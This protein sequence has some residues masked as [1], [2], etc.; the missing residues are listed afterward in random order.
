MTPL[1]ATKRRAKKATGGAVKIGAKGMKQF[2]DFIKTEMWN[3]FT[4]GGN[5]VIEVDIKKDCLK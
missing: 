2:L 1:H 3:P 5:V 4:I